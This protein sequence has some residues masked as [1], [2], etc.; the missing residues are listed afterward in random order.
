VSLSLRVHY[1]QH[2]AFENLG[3]MESYFHDTGAAVSCTRFYKNETLPSPVDLDWLVIMGGPMG[4]YD[5]QRY[6]WLKHE[7]EFISTV[8]KSGKTVLGI[9][10]GAQLLACV[11]GSKVY[12][13]K[14][15]E[16]GWFPLEVKALSAHTILHG[17]I[18][19]QILTF[20]WHSDTFD[21]PESAVLLASTPGCTNQGFII[22]D[23]VI[24]L[25]FH[26]ESTPNSARAL[27]DHCPDDL[28]GSEW[29]QSPETILSATR[30]FEVINALMVSIL[31]RL[32]NI[33]R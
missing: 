29:V 17:V 23:R 11:L 28:D 15:R 2:V 8:I 1:L 4:V 19:D 5:E 32:R 7:K 3:S 13:N 10:L 12:K 24:G 20:H 6:P 26:L 30:R 16:I 33:K 31:E 27:I 25:Q 22:G 21:L 14:H 18:P 9:C